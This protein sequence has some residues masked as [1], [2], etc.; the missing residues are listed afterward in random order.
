MKVEFCGQSA[1]DPDNWQA[2]SSRL[3]NCYREPSQGET[4]FT[5]KSDLG[6]AA[7]STVSGVFFRAME[8]IEAN[9][10]VSCGSALWKIDVSGGAVSLGV[11][12]DSAEASLAG[13]NGDVTLCVGQAY[14]LWNGTSLSTPSAGAFSAFGSLDYIGNYT[15][16]TEYN[17][18]RFQWSDLADASTLPGLN[19]SSADGKDDKIIRCAAVN[20][21]LYIFKEKSHEIW[22]VT[23]EAGANAFLRQAGGV[24]E[25]GLKAFG[26]FSKVPGGSAFFV[27]ADG[28]AHIIGVG[29]VSIPPVET[30]IKT[31]G[32]DR[33]L[34]WEDEGHTMCAII[35]R[36]APAWVYDLATGEWHER[37]QGLDLEPW[38]AAGSAKLAGS[39]YVGRAGGDVLKLARSNDDAGV[40]LIRSMV[41]RTMTNDANRITINEL[42][43]FGRIGWA[44]GSVDMRMSKDEGQTWGG[45]KQRSWAVGE[46]NKRIVW[47]KLGQARQWTAE[48]RISDAQEI[49]LNAQGRVA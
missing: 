7:F 34:A 19:F 4:G 21:L 39:W 47:R 27:G 24:V 49:S 30:A 48:I 44:A 6:M 36:N 15:V 29:P 40:P 18:I 23:G 2:S 10:Y 26:L 46:Y 37:A 35:F 20:G 31:L 16:L 9:L 17:G 42:E 33:C 3:V 22:Y 43:V 14:Y 11:T 13:N 8:E 1:R 12:A 32:P 28:R 41:S 25:T 38:Q 45:W 5:I